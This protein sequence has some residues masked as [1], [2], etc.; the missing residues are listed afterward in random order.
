MKCLV[1]RQESENVELKELPQRIPRKLVEEAARSRL[2]PRPIPS[3][4]LERDEIAVRAPLCAPC[5]AKV[6]SGEIG[7]D[8]IAL[9]ALI[10]SM[11]QSS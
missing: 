9:R 7:G 1:C 5:C 2:L 6:R 8:E 10:V 3:S 11:Q 4:L